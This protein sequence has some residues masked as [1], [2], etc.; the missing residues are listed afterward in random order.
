MMEEN[1]TTT[2]EKRV[3]L[4]ERGNVGSLDELLEGEP[5]YHLD[6]GVRI[7]WSVGVILAGLIVWI[8]LMLVAGFTMNS[9]MGID[10][11]MFPIFFF[12]LIVLLLLPYLVWTELNYHNYTYQFRK[13]RL[14]IRKGV[15]NKERTVIPYDRIQNIN[16][17]R[18]VLQRTLGIATIKIETAGTNPWESE[19]IIDGIGDYHGFIT[20]TMGLVERTRH[21]D[22]KKLEKVKHEEDTELFYLKQILAQLIELKRVT[23]LKDKP[24]AETESKPKLKDEIGKL[25]RSKKRKKK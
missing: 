13:K 18:N 9:I 5:I 17:N 14:V 20:H 24:P 16:I 7:Y 11:G 8:I 10:K 21:E 1:I 3:T 23:E 15:L 19:G 22:E 12:V 2:E 25:M 6:P 4:S